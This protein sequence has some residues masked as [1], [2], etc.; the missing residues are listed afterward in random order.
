VAA[1]Y[2]LLVAVLA[3]NLGAFLGSRLLVAR[4]FNVAGGLVVLGLEHGPWA[5]VQLWRRLAFAL[6]GPASCYLCAVALLTLGS[7]VGGK[8]VV[9]EQSMRVVVAPGLPAQAAGL[10]DGD[11]ILSV[12]GVKTDDWP[13]LKAAVAQ[14]AGKEMEVAVERDGQEISLRPTPS[15][16]GKIGVGPPVRRETV[17]LGASITDALIEPVRVWG[18][19]ARGIKQALSG[20][21]SIEAVGP[22]G[23]VKE[24]GRA[25]TTSSGAIFQFVGALNAYYLWIPT[26]AALV[27]FPRSRKG[28][29]P[30]A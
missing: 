28:R 25:G 15:S 21:E 3:L 2:L 24:T 9:D 11:R 7:A 22:V 10:R 30:A 27:L 13:S 6:A 29:P 16:L 26:L 23:I 4:T 1:G 5:G 19:A 18:A 8:Q 14:H 20:S 17:G 12:D